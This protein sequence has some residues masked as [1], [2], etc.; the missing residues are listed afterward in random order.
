MKTYECMLLVDPTVAAKDW[1]RVL[2]E[3][4]RIAK[5]NGASVIS[6][7]RYGERKL[8]FP[9]KKS[10][11]GTYVLSYLTAPGKS[12]TRIRSDFQLSEIILR[13]LVIAHD[14][15]LRKEAPKDF[16]TAGPLPPRTDRPGFGPPGMGGGPGG[17]RPWEDR[18][19]RMPSPMG[20]DRG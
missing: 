19:P 1:P 12:V 8:A 17:G 5:R 2:E 4:E 3:V 16:E 15:E 7:L 11:R 9:V 6:T 18:G 20:M 10:N 13:N 14:G